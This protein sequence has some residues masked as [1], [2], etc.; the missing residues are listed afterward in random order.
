MPPVNPAAVARR[1]GPP[2][3]TDEIRNRMR[4]NSAGRD[5]G[6]E[7]ALRRELHG[8][9]VRYR[10]GHRIELP[11]RRAVKPD[12]TWREARVAVFVDGCFWHQCPDHGRAPKSN[13]DYWV[14]KLARNV[15]R[16]QAQTAALHALGWKV[17]RL[18]EH[19]LKTECGVR[20]AAA[21]VTDLLDWVPTSWS[22]Q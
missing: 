19:E 13:L 1:S 11:G 12:L 2:S 7:M 15:E 9:G 16:D 3:T 4:A 5:T 14:P 21:L 6:P 20:E 17:L 22:W 10:L 18:W 8:M